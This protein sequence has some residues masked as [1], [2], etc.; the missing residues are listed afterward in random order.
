MQMKPIAT[1]PPD[2]LAP[3]PVNLHLLEKIKMLCKAI[4]E[5]EP[6]FSTLNENISELESLVLPERSVRTPGLNG[7]SGVSELE[8]ACLNAAY[9]RWE[10]ELER[11]YAEAVLSGAES[12]ITNYL[13]C[14]RFHN[15]VEQELALVPFPPPRRSLF[16]GSGPFPITA[17]Y[18]TLFTSG[19]VDCLDRDPA[20]VDTSRRVIER[21]GFSDRVRVFHGIGESFDVKD[22]DLVIIAL[23]AKPKRRILRNLRKRV[24][25][26]CRVLC[27]TSY[28][29]RTLIYDPTPEGAL[30]GFQVAARRIADGDQTIS[31]LLLE[32]TAKRAE[33]IQLR[34]VSEID[35]E[36]GAGILRV[37]NRVLERETTIGFPGPLDAQAGA[38]LIADLQADVKARRKH[39]LVAERDGFIVGQTILTPHHLPNCKHLIELSRGIID[40]S[41]RGAGLVLRAFHEI[42]KK[43]EE[44]G[45]E[46]ICLD[47]RAGT[48]AAELWKSFGFTTFGV[49]PDYARIG[50]RIYKGLYMSQTVAALK[51]R[52][53]RMSG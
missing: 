50:G 24:R 22:Y 3:D 44:I 35:E 52:L 42:V 13:L 39:V 30:Q 48:V 11:R 9:C 43:C 6:D 27:R 23:L 38:R 49:L 33:R 4:Q 20:A 34:W 1:L 21:L 15:L 47:V 19:V 17:I 18:L 28:G 14:D 16:I 45:S 2:S 26:D 51:Q 10:T 12:D 53:E 7:S 29:L 5:N 36:V 32:P 31:T 37:M 40:P 8:R 46:I 41:F 25:P